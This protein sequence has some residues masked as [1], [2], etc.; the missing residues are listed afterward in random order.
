M[1]WHHSLL[2]EMNES[3]AGGCSSAAG[4]KLSVCR[5]E[6]HCGYSLL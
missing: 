1:L 3:L 5:K 6:R 4:R 2:N